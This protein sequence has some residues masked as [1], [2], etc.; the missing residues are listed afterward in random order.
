MKPNPLNPTKRY[1]SGL[2]ERQVLI[3]IIALLVGLI[4]GALSQARRRAEAARAKSGSQGSDKQRT[5]PTK[6][7]GQTK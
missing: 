2:I 6:T 5:F 7:A 4:L 1:Q 3:A